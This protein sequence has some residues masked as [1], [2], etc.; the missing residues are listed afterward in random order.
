MPWDELSAV[1]SAVKDGEVRAAE[2]IER[3]ERSP[4]WGWV[5]MDPE[6]QVILPRAG[7]ERTLA[8]AQGVVHHVAQ[9]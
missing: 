8:M 7:G 2:A 3:L 6:R 1:L 4:H 5:A 9:V